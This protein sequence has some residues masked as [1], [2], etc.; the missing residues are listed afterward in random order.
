MC[1]KNLIIY[2][3]NYYKIFIIL[4]IKINIPVKLINLLSIT[5][6]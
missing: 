4:I 1:V 2:H 6:L 3:Y 5:L